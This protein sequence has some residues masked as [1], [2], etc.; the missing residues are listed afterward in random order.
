MPTLTKADLARLVASARDVTVIRAEAIVAAIFDSMAESLAR[1]E[2]IEL[3]G[4]GSFRVRQRRPRQGRNPKLGIRV[5][6]PAKRVPFFRASTLVKA[7][8]AGTRG[9]PSRLTIRRAVPNP[10]DDVLHV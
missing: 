3:R 5:D 10:Q 6:V 7:R 2:K 1:G 9:A 8:L 4:F